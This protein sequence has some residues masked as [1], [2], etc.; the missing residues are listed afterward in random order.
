MPRIGSFEV[1]YKG[2]LIYS[3]LKHG[4]WPKCEDVVR[5]CEALILYLNEWP[6][7]P[8]IDSND[9]HLPQLAVG[10]LDV[11]DIDPGLMFLEYQKP[12]SNTIQVEM[13]EPEAVIKDTVM[14]A[15][16]E[17]PEDITG[18]PVFQE[19][20]EGTRSK[21]I[22]ELLAKTLNRGM[23]RRLKDKKDNSEWSFKQMLISTKHLQVNSFNA[24]D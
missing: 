23:W 2:I 19:G 13:S 21:F 20:K 1:S 24:H 5:K 12:E 16:I 17:T 14:T 22:N 11:T 15:T 8:S 6:P 3:K 10:I 7:N 4:T 18:Y 9:F